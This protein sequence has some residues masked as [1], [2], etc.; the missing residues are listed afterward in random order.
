MAVSQPAGSIEGKLRVTIQGEVIE[1]Y[2][3]TVRSSEVTFERYT[4]AIREST[5]MYLLPSSQVLT[6]FVMVNKLSRA[7]KQHMRTLSNSAMYMCAKKV[8]QEVLCRMPSNTS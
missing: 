2:F 5:S 6:N 4:T 1:N 3:G 8:D 7:C